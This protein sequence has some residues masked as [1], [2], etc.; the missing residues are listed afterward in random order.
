MLGNSNMATS[1]ELAKKSLYASD[2]DVL[3]HPELLSQD[4]LQLILNE[5]KVSYK[6]CGSRDQLVDLYVRHVIPRPQRT[7][8]NNRW[9]MRM[10]KIRGKHSLV[11]PRTDRDHLTSP[12]FS[13]GSPNLKKPEMSTVPSSGVADRLKPPPALNLANPIRRLS[14]SSSATSSSPS[15]SL[16]LSLSSSST[17]SSSSSNKIFSRCPGTASLKRE[18]NC[19]GELMSPEVKKKIQHVTWP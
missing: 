2:V 4:F 9:G 17:S 3:L 15:S 7:L 14:G 1:Y 12:S 18:A 13:C 6:D 10:A 8:P 11:G 16:S 5:K 19:S